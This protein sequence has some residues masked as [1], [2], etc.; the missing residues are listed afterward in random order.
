MR[1][2]VSAQYACGFRAANE[3]RALARWKAG[4]ETEFPKGDDL[5]GLRAIP[6]DDREPEYLVWSRDEGTS[7]CRTGT[8]R[9]PS[10][11]ASRLTRFRGALPAPV[12]R[13]DE[14]ARFDC[15]RSGDRSA[16]AVH[17]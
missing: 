1:Q 11:S 7:G 13:G 5:P 2:D 3:R 15:A 17:G 14:A 10:G 9:A 4:R 16:G 6:V 8:D 12:V